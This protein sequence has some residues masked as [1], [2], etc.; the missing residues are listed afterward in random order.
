M[1]GGAVLS[2][3]LGGGVRAE[4]G[5]ARAELLAWCGTSARAPAYPA[6]K[7]GPGPDAKAVGATMGASG[8]C[9]GS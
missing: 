5:A 2:T 3:G 6:S 7:L 8:A 4:Y 1:L 9:E